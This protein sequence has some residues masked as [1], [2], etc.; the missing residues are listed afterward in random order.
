VVTSRPELADRVR[1]LRAHGERPRYHHRVVGSTARL[2]ALQ[3]AVL[4][5]KLTRLDGWNDERRRLGATLRA[6]LTSP[7]EGRG[8]VDGARGTAA[9]DPVRLPFP[10]ADHVYHLFVVRCARRDALREHLAEHGAASAIHYP[11]PIHRTGAYAELGLA[12]GSL[13]VS[14]SLA[15]R[16]CSLPIF[17]GMSDAELEQV[18]GAVAAFTGDDAAGFA[19]AADF[20]QC[21]KDATAQAR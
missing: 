14:E 3:A 6:R 13:P 1:L 21:T 2:D 11:V 15:D 17:P 12:P 16:I 5:R 8:T 18:A 7:G 10:E 4:R 9:V 20:V 19:Y